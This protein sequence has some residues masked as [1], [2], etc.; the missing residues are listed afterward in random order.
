MKVLEYLR[1]FVGFIWLVMGV[2]N[3]ARY[4]RVSLEGTDRPGLLA[5]YSVLVA[6]MLTCAYIL[7]RPSRD[8]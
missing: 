4:V 8:T 5:L 7:I 3:L 1:T 6:F 2:G